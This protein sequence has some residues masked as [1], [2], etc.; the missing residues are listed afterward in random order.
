MS[1]RARETVDSQA[2]ECTKLSPI[3]GAVVSSV[4]TTRAA[5]PA[6]AA[7]LRQL[8]AQHKLLIIRGATKLSVA[9]LATFGRSL[10]LGATEEFGAKKLA[11]S[12]IGGTADPAVRELVYG[13]STPPADINVWQAARRG[14]ERP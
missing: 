2:L 11:D 5:S 8:L 7:Q 14:L 13:P 12:Y 9:Q 6:V 1:K 4:D 3:L 10:E